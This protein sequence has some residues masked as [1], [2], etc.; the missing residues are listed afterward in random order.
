M[1]TPIFINDLH[2]PTYMYVYI[3]VYIYTRPINTLKGL[4]S[5][6]VAR[7]ERSHRTIVQPDFVWFGLFL[8][9]DELALLVARRKWENGSC[10]K[11]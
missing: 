10:C 1:H 3:Y 2:L 7:V 9:G 5:E 4:S 8:P 6:L 11:V